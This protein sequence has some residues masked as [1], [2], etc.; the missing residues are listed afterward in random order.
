MPIR[1]IYGPPVGGIP[2]RFFSEAAV[3][4]FA[5]G[6]ARDLWPPSRLLAPFE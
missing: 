4:Q 2:A 1:A 6:G 5:R 3:D